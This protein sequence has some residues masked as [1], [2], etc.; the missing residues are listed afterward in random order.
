MG[1]K[2]VLVGMPVRPGESAKLGAALGLYGWT[3]QT[4]QDQLDPAERTAIMRSHASSSVLPLTFDMLWC[5]AL[6]GFERGEVTHFAMIHDDVI[7]Q[8]NWLGILIEEL[9]KYEADIVSAIIAL[10]DERGLTSTAIDETGDPWNP[11][12][13]S[14]TEVF[15]E[16][17]TFTHPKI[18]LN[19]GLWVC[20]LSRDWVRR[21]LAH[22]DGRTALV[23]S[24]VQRNRIVRD[25]TT[26]HW[27][28]QM[29]SEDWEFCRAARNAGATKLYATRRVKVIHEGPPYVNDRPWGTHK[30]EPELVR[31]A[32]EPIEPIPAPLG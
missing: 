15:R 1:K 7:P 19:S 9:D 16:A 23:A 2:K 22:P 3:F 14:F 18:L 20:D 31:P 32:S 21:T 28:P 10:K 4:P 24:F 8:S 25:K 30:T 11:R 12:R 29:R 13:L 5:G 27:M 26:G 17:E 6:N